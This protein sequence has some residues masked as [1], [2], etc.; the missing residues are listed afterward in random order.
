LAR[1]SRRMSWIGVV[2]AAPV[3]LGYLTIPAGAAPTARTVTITGV[4]CDRN[5]VF[6]VPQAVANL[7]SLHE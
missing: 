6:P 1:S 7:E 5:Q 3:V 4:E 2:A